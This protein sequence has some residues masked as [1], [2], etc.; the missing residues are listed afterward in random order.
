MSLSFE[1]QAW[2]AQHGSTARDNPRV[3]MVVP[4]EHEGHLSESMARADVLALLGPPD[5]ATE[6][7]DQYRLGVSPVGIDHESY[8]IEYNEFNQVLRFQVRRG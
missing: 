5:H 8:V 2:R 4:L 3:F 1:P 7:S 6:R